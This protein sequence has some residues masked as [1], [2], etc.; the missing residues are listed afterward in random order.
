MNE[1]TRIHIINTARRHF[2]NASYRKVTID[3]IAHSLGMSKK[4][5]YTYFSSK[6]ELLRETMRYTRQEIAQDLESILAQDHLPFMKRFQKILFVI[7]NLTQ[8]VR[9]EFLV[10]LQRTHPDIWQEMEAF[11][12]NQIYTKLGGLI[13][14]GIAAGNLRNDIDPQFI[15]LMFYT[16]AQNIICP[17]TLSQI[18]FSAS[19]AFRSIVKTIFEGILTEEVRHEYPFILPESA[20]WEEDPSHA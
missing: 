8:S 13:R 3:E 17:E 11:R 2:F 4:T 15:I 14:E 1:H 7:L 5:L 18:P 12:K 19:D 10:D 16:L 6:E 9:K 20:G